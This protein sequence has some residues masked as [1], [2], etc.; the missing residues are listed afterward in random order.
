MKTKLSISC[1]IL[2][3]A[4]TTLSCIKEESLEEQN[5]EL[6]FSS[7]FQLLYPNGNIRE[8]G[9][10]LFEE[11]SVLSNSSIR[12]QS[13]THTEVDW[14]TFKN[15]NITGTGSYNLLYNPSAEALFEG[16]Y[17]T[18]VDPVFWTSQGSN[19]NQGGTLVISSYENG[20]I[21][22]NYQFTAWRF[23][24]SLNREVGWGISG[25]FENIPYR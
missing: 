8:N 7:S 22:G 6:P 5:I 19:S 4:F 17:S 21:S 12:I 16:V 24:S 9:S 20:Y 3:I 13:S 1:L 11:V 10:G 14:V 15:I 2:F 23:S 18:A 25:N